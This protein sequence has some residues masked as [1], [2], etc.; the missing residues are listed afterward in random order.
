MASTTS[1]NHKLTWFL[2]YF[3]SVSF[4]PISFCTMKWSPQHAMK[5][6][7]HTLQLSKIQYGQ[8]CTLGTTKLIQPQCMEFLSALARQIKLKSLEIVSNYDVNPRG[9]VVV[10]TNLVRKGNGAGLVKLLER[11]EELNV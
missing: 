1:Q 11:R 3:V 2:I 8:D 9:S 5:A 10:V 7:L 6:Y 4:I